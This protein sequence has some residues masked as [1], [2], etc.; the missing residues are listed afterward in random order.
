MLPEGY[1]TVRC[2]LLG[3]GEQGSSNF[4]TLHTN[5]YMAGFE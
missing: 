3:G 4:P 2:Q 5:Q 1:A